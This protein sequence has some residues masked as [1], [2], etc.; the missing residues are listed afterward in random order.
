MKRII[1]AFFALLLAINPAAAAWTHTQ[2]ASV[3]LNTTT[4]S[5]L[6]LSFGSAVSSNG[7]VSGFVIFDNSIPASLT[8]VTDDKSNTY[9]IVDTV[10]DAVNDQTIVSFYLTNISNGPITITAHFSASTDFFAMGL[11]EDNPGAGQTASI[12][13]HNAAL[14]SIP[15][16]TTGTNNVSS[17]SATTT[18]NGDLIKGF[19]VNSGG[20]TTFSAG[21]SPIA[22]TQRTHA[23]GDATHFG[24]T[25]EDFVQTTAGSIAVTFGN[26][27][28]DPVTIVKADAFML[29]FQSAASGGATPRLRSL[30]GV[31]Q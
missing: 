14:T 21:T 25:T 26:S 13:G 2:S 12:D 28:S 3:T 18:A 20:L 1:A 16:S 19:V 6:A 30:M 22:F 23:A 10:T 4:G 27:V 24:M 8:S 7:T 17:G 29:A 31:G 5:S 11:E 9:T 15:T